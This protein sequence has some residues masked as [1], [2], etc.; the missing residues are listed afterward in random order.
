MS[1]A[2]RLST[3]LVSVEA[4]ATTPLSIEV[5]NRGEETDRFELEVEG[6]DPEW[7]AVPV[8]SFVVG[9]GETTAE[10]VFFRV[11]RASE[12]LAG[13]YPFV[14]KVRSLASG[15]QRTAQGVLQIQAYHHVSAEINPKKGTISAFKRR[16]DFVI[17]VVN[18]GNTE[19]TLQLFGSDPEEGLAFDFDQ[20]T[21]TVAPGQQREV[22][23]IAQ[24]AT[25]R[26][27]S[28]SRL[29]GFSVTARSVDGSMVAAAAHAQLEQRSVLSPATLVFWSVIILAGYMWWRAMPRPP[30]LEMGVRKD[31]VTYG[32]PVTIWWRMRDAGR[33]H[34][35]AEGRTIFD[36]PTDEGHVDYIAKR[37]GQ[38]EIAGFAEGREK[39]RSEIQRSVVNVVVPPPAPLPAIVAF[40]ASPT[41]VTVGESTIFSYKFNDAVERATLSPLNLQL[42]PNDDKVEVPITQ[43]GAKTFT[44]IA[45]NRDRKAV[46]KTVTIT[47]VPSPS[48]AQVITF[49]VTPVRVSYPG[50][51]VT[52]SW[53][54]TNAVFAQITPNYNST[55]NEVDASKGKFD[56]YVDKPT[57]FT[58]TAKDKNNKEVTQ[59]ARVTVE[60]PPPAPDDGTG[61][62]G[63]DATPP[64]AGR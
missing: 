44:I 23:F 37:G 38:L 27:F 9:P 54:L 43:E 46:K 41:R 34:I 32:Q 33:V 60:A 61:T 18:L 13:N 28:T 47:G 62:V 30:V 56:I 45:E 8:P 25:T 4:G 15:D 17:T 63:P 42:N 52:V 29:F 35:E 48:E 5:A 19:H 14:I 55:T 1:F 64:G 51:L 49:N 10:K 2:I 12:S 26:F 21:I 31:V 3:D 59:T 16:D 39:K 40:S 50:Q 20:D 24:P 22:H 36:G 53:Q 7:T 6:L 11:P 58:L 57:T